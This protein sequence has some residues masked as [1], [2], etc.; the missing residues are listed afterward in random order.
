M[1]DEVKEK[2]I[3][4]IIIKEIHDTP[5]VVD[6]SPLMALI[7]ANAI[8]INDLM[9]E[10]KDISKNTNESTATPSDNDAVI[11]LLVAMAIDI[12]NLKETS[13]GD[14]G[15]VSTQSVPLIQLLQDAILQNSSQY[16]EIVNQLT[17]IK[18][19]L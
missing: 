16:E 17:I 10:V 13:E 12:S 19:I 18:D 14:T 9:T 3:E 2:I 1:A 15:G 5:V 4:K 8:A 11:S 6:L 7:E